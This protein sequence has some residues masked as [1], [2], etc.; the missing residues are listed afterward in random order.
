MSQVRIKDRD[1]NI[2][3]FRLALLMSEISTNYETADLVYQVFQ[4]MKTKGDKFNVKDACKLKTTHEQKW[5]KYHNPPPELK[6]E[7]DSN[8]ETKE[9][10]VKDWM[11]KR[12]LSTR[13]YTVFLGITEDRYNYSMRFYGTKNPLIKDITRK[14][15]LRVQHAG[16]KTWDEFVKLRGY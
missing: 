14:S 1:T 2:E 13:L 8:Q 11:E 5:L 4:E 9:E 6:F 3:V 15:F 10:T 7:P 16:V 12:N